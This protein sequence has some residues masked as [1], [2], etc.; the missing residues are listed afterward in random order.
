MSPVFI[1]GSYDAERV[2]LPGPITPSVPTSTLRR[3]VSIAWIV[4]APICMAATYQVFQLQ[5]W[6]PPQP[7]GY[8][9]SGGL[10]ETRR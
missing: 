5:V 7:A 8:R 1:T 9:W 2:I 6:L 4:S 3:V 10:G